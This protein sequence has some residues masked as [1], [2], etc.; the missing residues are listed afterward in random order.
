MSKNRADAVVEPLV[1]NVPIAMRGVD[2]KTLNRI[3][4]RIVDDSNTKFV[5]EIS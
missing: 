3:V 2:E 1:R 4:E 5:L